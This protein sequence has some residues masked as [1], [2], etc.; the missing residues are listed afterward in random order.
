MPQPVHPV[1]DTKQDVTAALLIIGDEILSGRTQDRNLQYIA[2]GLNERGIRLVEARV[3]VDEPEAIVQAVDALRARYDHVF[4]TGGIGPTHDDVTAAAI[5]R[6]FGVAMERN[7]EALALLQDHYQPDQLNAARLRMAD[8]PAGA[9]LID[10]PVSRAPGFRLGN[11][12][13]LP[14]VPMIMQAMFDGVVAGLAG[15]AKTLSCTV[16]CFLREGDLAE[17]LATVQAAHPQVAIGSYPFMRLDRFGTSVVLRAIDQARLEDA[18]A[19]ACESIRALGG[20]PMRDDPRAP[21][22]EPG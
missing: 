11:V 12:H 13:V 8:I 19:A 5:A 1:S 14:G 16:T 21:A 15:G 10:N 4:T 6:A 22:D 7:A 20:E 17:A 18:A 2:R 9:A 3:V